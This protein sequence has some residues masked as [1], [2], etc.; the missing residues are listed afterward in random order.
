MKRILFA[1]ATLVLV[2]LL[3]A[4]QVPAEPDKIALAAM[5]TVKTQLRLPQGT[6][7]RFIRQ[8]ESPLPDFYSVP[9]LL[10]APDSEFLPDPR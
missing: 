1:V 7:V 3:S 10:M 4:S 8:R 6:E 2:G 5:D 9:L